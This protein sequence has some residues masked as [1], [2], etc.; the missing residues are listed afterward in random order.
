MRKLLTTRFVETTRPS[1]SRAEYVDTMTP[2]LALRVGPRSKTWV[3]L[4]K[5]R[6]GQVRRQRLGRH[7]AMSLAAARLAARE[8]MQAV[9]RGR[10]P[11][12]DAARAKRDTFGALAEQYLDRHAKLMKRSWAEDAR[13]LHK[14]LLPVWRDLPVRDLSRRAI[15]EHLDQI[16]DRAP[17]VANRTLALVSKMLN[18]AVDREWL[19]ANPAARLAK[20]AREQARERVLSDAEIAELW[21]ALAEAEER[22]ELLERAA[23]PR[24]AAHQ[25]GPSLRPVLA[26]WLRLRLLTA[27]RGGEVLAMRWSDLQWA[28]ATWTIPTAVA[29]NGNAH[30]VPLSAPVLEILQRR[31]ALVEAIGASD[32]PWVFV[33]ERRTG[34]V[35]HRARKVS[36]A[37]LLPSATNVRA[38]DLRRT[39]AS[40]MARLGVPR[41]TIARV[42]N[43]VDGGS[44]T[45]AV[46]NRYSYLA[47]KRVALERWAA[48]VARLTAQRHAPGPGSSSSGGA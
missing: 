13:I 22:Y 34:S 23:A 8:S 15:R 38:H 10:D 37:P 28:E 2:G 48:E 12:A 30:V 40:G 14:D 21:H 19:D 31:R 47:E 32:I 42:L 16:A 44:R 6:D 18:F 29:K 35:A 17:V 11:V 36:L 20:P 45:T 33:N 1:D 26:D 9:H 25:P 7:P 41:E 24:A 46:Y 27:Q 4:Y 5:T 39:A 43:H 3:A